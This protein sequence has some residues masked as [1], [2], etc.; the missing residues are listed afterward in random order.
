MCEATNASCCLVCKKYK[1]KIKVFKCI[2]K[3]LR[4]KYFCE[5]RLGKGAWQRGRYA[6][7]T[8]QQITA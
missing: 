6:G 7:G 3:L 2:K 4:L 8:Q 1:W 5:L